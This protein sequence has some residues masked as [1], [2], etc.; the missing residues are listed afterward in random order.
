M[1]KKALP[2][3]VS[4]AAAVTMSAA[5]AAMYVNERGTG[6]ALIYPYFSAENGNTT[7]VNIVNTTG[8]HKAVKVRILEGENSQEVLD[9][10]LYLSPED[11]FSFAISAD[12]ATGGGQLT[13]GD[14]SCTVPA[15]TGAVPFR[16]YLYA[17][18]KAADDATTTTVN[19]AYD[20]T[21]I[22]RT[23]SGYIEVIEMGQ[24]DSSLTAAQAV[25]GPALDAVMDPDYDLTVAQAMTHGA[26]GVPA[27]CQM[28]V[29]AWSTFGGA[30]LTRGQW[31]AD[32]QNGNKGTSEFTAAWNGGGLYGYATI[33]NVPD[34]SAIG[35]DAV[36]I[37][38]LVDA[39]GNG[40]TGAAMHYASATQDP[41]FTDAAIDNESIVV[42]NGV[43][44]TLSFAAYGGVDGLQA[45]NSTI[46]A[47]SVQNDYVTDSTI[48]AETDWVLTFPTKTFHVTP[49]PA[50]EPFN[51]R[52]NGQTACEPSSLASVDREESTPPPTVVNGGGVDFSP[53]PPSTPGTP[54]GNDDVNLCYEASIVQFGGT[55]S[56]A[57]ETDSLAIGVSALLDAS[58]GWA[59][60]S[61]D[62]A[63]TTTVEPGTRTITGAGANNT[64]T[65]MT[66]LPVV[67]FAVQKYVNNTVGAGA[68]YAMATEHKTTIVTS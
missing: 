34:G 59:T 26:D 49:D 17:A 64:S 42:V 13:T 23:A 51:Y 35:Y 8:A 32:A 63:A 40:I 31:N 16:E 55:G 10:N 38:D 58:D 5:H 33:I 60:L 25:V 62:P 9:F 52:W 2:L 56:S 39:D 46:M 18:D 14:N 50:V 44:S 53:A 19:E 29:D 1:K 43:S 65:T 66:G 27:N 37:D 54:P 20:N 30:T 28:L 47:T 24:I 22:T 15:I 48:G 6:E 61:F 3:A 68:N 4:A 57:V 21:S 12:S 45:L 36:A 41:R 67:G 7:N 11:H